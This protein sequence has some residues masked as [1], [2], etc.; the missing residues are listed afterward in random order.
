M[1]FQYRKYQR[2]IKERTKE[3]KKVEM[4][5]KEFTYGRGYS[6]D[7]VTI[8]DKIEQSQSICL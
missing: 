8:H 7:I 5:T 6:S 3:E 4:G 2:N 1:I